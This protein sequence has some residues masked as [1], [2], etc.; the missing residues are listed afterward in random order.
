MSISIASSVGRSGL[1]LCLL[2]SLGIAAAAGSVRWLGERRFAVVPETVALSG[3]ASPDDSGLQAAALV[4]QDNSAPPLVLLLSRGDAAFRARIDLID[5]AERSIDVQYYT[6][7]DDDI[8]RAMLTA[9]GEAADR[10]VAVRLLLDD[11]GLVGRE[12]MLAQ[13]AAAHEAF[14]LRVFNPTW[15]RSFRPFEYLARFPRA[16]RRM[17]NKSLTVDGAASIVGGRNIGEAYFGKDE[18]LRF[19]DLDVLAVGDVSEDTRG[20]FDRYWR[21]GIAFDIALLR[22]A[23]AR[24]SAD[25]RDNWSAAGRAALDRWRDRS[26]RRGGGVVRALQNG[27]A[28]DIPSA[29]RTIA[30]PPGKVIGDLEEVGGTVAPEVLRLLSTAR[31]DVLIS[32]PYLIP[33]DAGMSVFR[34]LRERGVAVTIL[35]NSYAANDVAAVH[36]GYRD[37]RKPLLELGISLHEFKPDAGAKAWRY[38]DSLVGRSKAALHTKAFVID[39]R[40][41]FVGSFN[42]DP[43]SAMHNTEM[44]VVVDSAGFATD[45]RANLELS[46]DQ[47]AWQVVLTPSGSL[48][49][50]DRAE[51]DVPVVAQADPGTVLPQRVL[52][53]LASWLPVDWLL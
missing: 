45:L 12:A 15:L 26:E 32:S 43:R 19:T 25:E 53:R 9:L 11:I 24:L 39:G 5:L 36:V 3:E 2:A 52:L 50:H 47:R 37:Y 7:E 4:E 20:A 29:M 8:G 27:Q 41:G 38:R 51:G 16:N 21:S 49:W 42:L 10:G 17:H 22:G 6:L 34:A 18:T 35:T 46:L 44:G 31:E 48:E 13:F 23:D 30:D 40:M 33:G 1:V 14:E 28:R